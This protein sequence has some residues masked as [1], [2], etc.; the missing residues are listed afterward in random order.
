[1]RLRMFEDQIGLPDFFE[2]EAPD[3][4]SDST[5]ENIGGTYMT[6]ANWDVLVSRGRVIRKD[7][8]ESDQHANIVVRKPDGSVLLVYRNDYL[9]RVLCQRAFD[10][11]KTIDFASHN[12]GMAGGIVE[13]DED[14][15]TENYGPAFKV[16]RVSVR[17]IKRDGTVSR[18]TEKTIVPSGVIGFFDRYVRIPY[19]RMTAFNL[20]HHEEF[21]MARPFV[22]AVDKAFAEAVPDRYAAQ[23]AIVSK[24]SADFYI[25]GTVFT[26]ITVNKNWQ[27]AVHKDAGD[28][29][30]GFGVMSAI[31]AGR[32]S[33]GYLVFPKYRV[34]VDMRT[35][36]VCLAD[37]HEWH[38]NTPIV[39]EKN[40]FMRLSMV[41][42]YREGMKNCG[43]AAEE[44]ARAKR[45]RGA[46]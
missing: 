41:F 31:E 5:L 8:T 43:S 21:E 30:P 36:G 12:R 42:Y 33:G 28:Y 17:R 34:A 1:M 13:T 37:V 3:C 32:Y 26:T 25:R 20:D 29:A 16:G 6:D 46:L 19:C 9:P 4:V 15:M 7:G 40:R 18:T 44:N 39:G 22:V 24:T 38:G 45:Q 14:G 11:F 27:T 23:Q 2:V 10:A 35:G